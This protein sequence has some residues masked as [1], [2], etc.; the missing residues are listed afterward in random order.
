[1]AWK[2]LKG[3]VLVD[4]RWVSVCKEQVELTNGQRIDDFYKVTIP[5][6]AG[7]VAL[8]PEGEVLLKREYRH[9]CAEDLIEFPAG[10]FEPDET[11]ALV[12]AKRELL[13]ETGYQSEHWTYLG[14]TVESSSKLTNRMHLFMAQ[15]CYN[16]SGLALD[17]TE[18]LEVVKVPMQQAIDMVM[19]NEICC[20]SSAH[21][22]LK[23]ARLL[24]M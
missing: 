9:A 18:E 11:D 24:G 7:I 10:T 3:E 20:N 1:M 8:T 5:D 15:D 19:R 21:A 12:V 4:S 23:V 14:A 16:V 17:A 6:A 22:L 13:E 2:T